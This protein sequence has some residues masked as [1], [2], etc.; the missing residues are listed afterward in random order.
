MRC[1]IIRHCAPAGIGTN[2]YSTYLNSLWP[3]VPGK[4]VK[5]NVPIYPPPGHFSQTG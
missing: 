2:A 1:L 5:P 3:P 4:I